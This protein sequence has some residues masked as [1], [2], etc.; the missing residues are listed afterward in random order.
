[1][2]HFISLTDLH[3][4]YGSLMW[5]RL[6]KTPCVVP[7]KWVQEV[8]FELASNRLHKFRLS[9]HRR[10]LLLKKNDGLFFRIF[11]FFLVLFIRLIAI[12]FI[13]SVALISIPE[14][15]TVWP[16]VPREESPDQFRPGTLLKGNQGKVEV[17]T[18]GL[19]P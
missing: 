3:K 1:M 8:R 13:N 16:W 9:N 4:S 14:T 10:G 17:Y 6:P 15:Y 7:L 18:T 11:W 5:L 19:Q 2:I 12:R